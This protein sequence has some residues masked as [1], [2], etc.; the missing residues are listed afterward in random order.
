MFFA[1]KYK[2]HDCTYTFEILYISIVCIRKSAVSYFLI[3]SMIY[4]YIKISEIR[5][6]RQ[7]KNFVSIFE[8]ECDK[9]VVQISKIQLSSKINALTSTLD[10]LLQK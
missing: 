8:Q 10:A 7:D 5:C 3:F 9:N 4:A 6:V 1:K 2:R